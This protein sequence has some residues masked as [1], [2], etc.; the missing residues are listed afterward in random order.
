MN[1]NPLFIDMHTHGPARP[2]VRSLRNVFLSDIDSFN[3]SG[4]QL[5][6]V[7]L[8]P[9]NIRG[10]E[11]PAI[12]KEQLHFALGY[13]K[14]VAVGETGLDKA[15]EMPMEMQE[16]I[17]RI[18][19]ELSESLQ[20]PLVIHCVRAFQE[21]LGLRKLLKAS[22]PWIFHGFSGSAQLAKQCLDAGC[23]LSFGPAIIKDHNRALHSLLHIGLD[24]FFLETDDSGLEIEAVYDRAA[25]LKQTNQ[26]VLGERIYKRFTKLFG[27]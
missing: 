25:Q 11:D 8:H 26:E 27:E 16:A 19:A 23:L 4:D 9:W 12:L 17:F 10:K 5:L 18:H 22:Q 2:G 21:V 15:I 14:V 7:G 1:T 13:P 6:S 24:D 3:T 20:M